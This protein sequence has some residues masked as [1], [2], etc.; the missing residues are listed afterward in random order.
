MEIYKRYEDMSQL[1]H[2]QLLVEDDGDVI[3]TV[4][5][6]PDAGQ[7]FGTSAQF[8]TVAGGGQSHKTRMALIQLIEAIKED[9]IKYPQCR[10]AESN[11]EPSLA[12]KENIK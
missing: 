7:H 4:Y 10:G 2:I 5:P 11:P 6:D 12:A 3:L 8:C 1:G 9:N